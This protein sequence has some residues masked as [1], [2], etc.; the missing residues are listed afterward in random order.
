[1]SEGGHKELALR[2]RLVAAGNVCSWTEPT[3]RCE[4]VEVMHRA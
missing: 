4:P 2:R 3:F 1:M